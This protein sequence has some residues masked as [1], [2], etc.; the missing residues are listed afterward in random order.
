MAPA[1]RTLRL[2]SSRRTILGR[3]RDSRSVRKKPLETLVAATAEGNRRP[4]QV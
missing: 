4:V 2:W 3:G 1:A